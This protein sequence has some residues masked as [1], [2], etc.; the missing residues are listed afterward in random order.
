MV[1]RLD[2]PKCSII[3]N[4]NKLRQISSFSS[5]LEIKKNELNHYNCMNQLY[6]YMFIINKII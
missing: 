1:R 4:L 2:K 6:G 5:F 3:K